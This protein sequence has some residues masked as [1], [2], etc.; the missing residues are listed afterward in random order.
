[1]PE[2]QK[3]MNLNEFLKVFFAAQDNQESRIGY[4]PNMV[5]DNENLQNLYQIIGSFANDLGS[6][7]RK[8]FEQYWNARNDSSPAA[9]DFLNM[10]KNITI[11]YAEDYNRRGLSEAYETVKHIVM[12]NKIQNPEYALRLLQAVKNDVRGDAN[13]RLEIR[14][15]IAMN[16]VSE[17]YDVYDYATALA[18]NQQS[19][20]YSDAPYELIQMLNDKMVRVDESLEPEV[21]KD[22]P[23]VEN[24]EKLGVKSLI[25]LAEEIMR[26]MQRQGASKEDFATMSKLKEELKQKYSIENILNNAPRNYAQEY[27]TQAS[28]KLADM[29]QEYKTM[30]NEIGQSRKYMTEYRQTLDDNNRQIR[31]LQDKIAKL[32]SKLA[33]EKSKNN[34]MRGTIK[35]FIAESEKRSAGSVLNKGKDLA[36]QIAQLKKHFQAEI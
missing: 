33:I 21:K 30:E 8:L 20:Y 22:V 32:E 13:L 36:A 6:K 12:N 3:Y 19:K 34:T 31:E 14:R 23:N 25:D 35:T 18:N 29:E 5:K 10:V 11:W 24:I 2:Q 7:T 1:M 15:L 4:F 27:E 26:I 17:P 16:P 28:I 9:Q